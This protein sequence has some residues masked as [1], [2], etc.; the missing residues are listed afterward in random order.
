MSDSHT[1]TPVPRRMERE[2]D[3]WSIRDVTDSEKEELS[4]AIHAV[5]PEEAL[6]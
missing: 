2:L 3:I 6:V 4:D 1:H 5:W